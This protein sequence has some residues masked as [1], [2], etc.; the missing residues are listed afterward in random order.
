M[1]PEN[2]GPAQVGYIQNFS[3][4]GM[5]PQLYFFPVEDLAAGGDIA[6]RVL[7]TVPTG[8]ELTVLDAKIIPNGDDAGIDASNTCVVAL[9]NG[10]NT[11]VTKTYNNTTLFPDRNVAGSLGTPSATY[12]KIAA[13]G[14]LKLSVTNGATANTPPFVVQLL[15]SLDQ[16]FG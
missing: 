7:A 3:G 15:V 2:Y 1:F 11:I 6:A 13:G 14:T 10:S 16:V 12:Q 4:K 9:A 5:A 8:Y